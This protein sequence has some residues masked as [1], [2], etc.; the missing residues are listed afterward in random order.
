MSLETTPSTVSGSR[1][2][3]VR[4]PEASFTATGIAC[5]S[6]TLSICGWDPMILSTRVV[7]VRGMPMTN[8]GASKEASSG[9][10]PRAP[11]WVSMASKIAAS[12][13][14]A[15]ASLAR[16]SAF[17]RLSH[18]NDSCRSPTSSNSLDRA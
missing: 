5:S 6:P 8:T 16:C 10:S 2:V 7:P 17:A 12:A 13:A 15:Y 18:W 14:G 11:Q 3:R 1:T 4:E 9:G